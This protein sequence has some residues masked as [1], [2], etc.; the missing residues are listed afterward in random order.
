GAGEGGPAAGGLADGRRPLA[1]ACGEDKGVEAAGRCCHRRDR[2]CDTVREDVEREPCGL[3]SV[4][5]PLLELEHR[6][7]SAGEALEAR[8]E[9]QVM[10]ERLAPQLARGAYGEQR[11]RAHAAHARL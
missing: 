5:Q 6:A 3:V 2:S 8:L 11:P 4:F 1:D 10:V 7:R 9:V